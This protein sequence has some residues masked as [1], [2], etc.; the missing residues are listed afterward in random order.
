MRGIIWGEEAP[1]V[2]RCLDEND[3]GLALGER[4][5]EEVQPWA[6]V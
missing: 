3:S 4:E 2:T 6:W 1:R 5:R